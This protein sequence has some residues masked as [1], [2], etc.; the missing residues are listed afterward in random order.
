MYLYLSTSRVSPFNQDIFTHIQTFNL[1]ENI[2][3]LHTHAHAY[4]HLLYNYYHCR[5]DKI[6]NCLFFN[7]LAFYQISRV[8]V[9]CVNL[10][11]IIEDLTL[12][13]LLFA[14]SREILFFYTTSDILIW[15]PVF[16]CNPNIDAL[17]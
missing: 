14:E 12:E 13:V 15:F 3:V 10:C 1:T 8:Y 5:V 17:S 4:E 9:A 16:F 11:C 7:V 6:Y 2:C